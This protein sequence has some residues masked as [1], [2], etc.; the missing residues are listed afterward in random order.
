VDVWQFP[1]R[2]LA[3]KWKGLV[4]QF[5]LSLHPPAH[6]LSSLGFFH[7]FPLSGLV[8]NGMFFDFLDDGF[9]LDSSFESSQRA[10]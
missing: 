10:L 6:A 5:S 2:L 4:F 3:E 7:P 8:V 9:L 1:S